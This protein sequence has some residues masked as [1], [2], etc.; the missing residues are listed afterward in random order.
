MIDFNKAMKSFKSYL[1]DYDKTDG[2]IKLKIRHTYGVVTSTEYI[3]KNLNLSKEDVDLAKLIAL[4]H[5]IAR[6]EQAKEFGNYRDYITFDHAE[7]GVKILFEDGLIRSFVE[8]EKY[9]EII[10]KAIKN[11]N[12]LFIEDGLNERELL[13]AQIIRD[14][15]KVDNFRGKTVDRFEDMYNTTI[16]NVEVATISD[17]IFND[18]MSNKVIVSSERVTDMDHWVSYLAFIFDFNFKSSINY[19]LEQDYINKIIDRVD[20]KNYDTKRK[21]EII[22]KHIYEFIDERLK[23]EK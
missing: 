21:M 1:N 10:L 22:R 4:L 11:H 23:E 7:L 14:A 2:M 8:D 15:D 17:K 12:K 19:I 16:E 6:F 9:D 5:D 3:A 13:F 20:Y 18:F